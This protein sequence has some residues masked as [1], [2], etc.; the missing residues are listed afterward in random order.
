MGN[1]NIK[2][3]TC[4]I[5]GASPSNSNPYVYSIEGLGKYDGY[6]ICDYCLFKRL[7]KSRFKK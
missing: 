5:C 4:D 7:V 2:C 6:K 1:A 3:S